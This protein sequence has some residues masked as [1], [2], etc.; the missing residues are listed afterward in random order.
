VPG[1][2]KLENYFKAFIM[3]MACS[4]SFEGESSI[5]LGLLILL[6]FAVYTD[7]KSNRI[8]NYLT[9][10]GMIAALFLHS[11][12]SGFNGFLL[13]VGGILL[14]FGI[15][16]IPYLMGGMGAGDVKLMAAV[17]GFLGAKATF[18]AFLL[19]AV[20]GGVYSIAL[21]L[22]S[23]NHFKGFFREKLMFLYSI[24]M[25]GQLFPI[26]TESSGQKPRLKYG[27]AIAFGTITYLM[28][29][30]FGFKFFA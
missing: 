2:Q 29:G 8:P 22:I 30:S 21:I 11:S 9:L 14:G 16:M 12:A 27:V 28:V 23:R 25:L 5:V 6:L 7:S 10:S 26:Q 4:Q 20:A 18:E 1:N 3:N 15:L 13:S 19:I 17:G 24:V